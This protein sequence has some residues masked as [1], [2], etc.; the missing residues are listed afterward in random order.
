M[1]KNPVTA[2][3]QASLVKSLQAEVVTEIDETAAS[4][5]VVVITTIMKTEI[6]RYQIEKIPLVA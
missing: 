4:K 5:S 6:T 3:V 1:R 2:G